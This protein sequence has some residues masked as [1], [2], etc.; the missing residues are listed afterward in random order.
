MRKFFPVVLSGL[1]A[2]SFSQLAA[3]QSATVQSD[4]KANVGA[5][6]NTKPGTTSDKSATTEKS[7]SAG[8]G[9]TKA[10]PTDNPNVTTD[11]QGREHVNKGK[12]KGQLKNKKE[13]KSKSDTSAAAG[14][15]ANTKSDTSIKSDNSANADS[16]SNTQLEKK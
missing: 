7:T 14:S 16:S 15:S 8:A 11:A 2:V 12:H 1:L 3:A 4:T 13:S 5:D 6:V 10:G 9:G